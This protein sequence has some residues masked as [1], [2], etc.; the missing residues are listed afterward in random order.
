MFYII[1][2]KKERREFEQGHNIPY[3][4]I[5]DTIAQDMEQLCNEHDEKATMIINIPAGTFDVMLFDA[6][7]IGYTDEES[8][9]NYDDALAAYYEAEDGVA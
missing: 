2:S 5:C 3:F 8:F 6:E 1:G 9:D 4:R 7:A